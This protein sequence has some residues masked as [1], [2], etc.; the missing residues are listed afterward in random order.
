[1]FLPCALPNMKQGRQRGRRRD[2][3]KRINNP[4]VH[5]HVLGSSFSEP[6]FIHLFLYVHFA[7]AHFADCNCTPQQLH[8]QVDAEI[9][10][11]KEDIF[12]TRIIIVTTTVIIQ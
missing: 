5:L 3:W 6:L 11:D 9:L 7:N 10:T 2:K 1:M 4:V 12:I 8:S